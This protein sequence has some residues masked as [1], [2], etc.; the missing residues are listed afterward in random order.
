[1]IGGN[2]QICSFCVMDAN[3]PG[4]VFDAET[5]QCNCCADAIGRRDH[6]WWP[7]AEGADRMAR[8][9]A[10]LKEEGRDKPYDCMVG[11]SGGIDSAYLAHVMATQYGLRL[12]AVHVD[13][14]WNSAAAVANIEALV[15]KLDIDLHTTVIEWSEMRD[16]QVAFLRS[17]VY[18][19]DFPQDHAFFTTLMRVA[20]SYGLRNFLSGVNYSSESVGS[21]LGGSVTAY[22]GKHL[23]AIHK[24]FGTKSLVQFP[25]MTLFEYFWGARVLKKPMVSKPLNY[26]DYDKE[27]AKEVLRDVYGWRDYGP[28]H[29]ES[30][31]TKFY[32]E[33]YLVRKHDTDKRRVHLASLIVSDQMSREMAVEQLSHPPIEP[34]QEDRDMRFISKKLALPREELDEILAKAPVPHTAYPNDVRLHQLMMGTRGYLRTLPRLF[35]RKSLTSAS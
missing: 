13:G 23:R 17:G 30:R 4:V 18:N 7:N 27:K 5:G 2:V 25:V 12:L 3:T 31:F 8:L 24:R 11:L 28:K 19:Q 20:R 35:R 14:G 32:Q 34:V 26:L 16:L 21:P 9:V 33:V 15:R 22:D 29:S 6:E 1:M 10:R